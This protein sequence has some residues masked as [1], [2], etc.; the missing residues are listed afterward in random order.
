MH[1]GY[2]G[3]YDQIKFGDVWYL[4]SRI[5]IVEI[6]ANAITLPFTSVYAVNM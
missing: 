5:V 4:L 1:A 6:I 3:K 2:K